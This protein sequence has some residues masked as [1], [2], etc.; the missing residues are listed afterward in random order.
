MQ[1]DLLSRLPDQGDRALT[2][3]AMADKGPRRNSGGSIVSTYQLSGTLFYVGTLWGEKPVRDSMHRLR[4]SRPHGRRWIFSAAGRDRED[5]KAIRSVRRSVADRTGSA[6]VPVRDSHGDEAGA[7]RRTSFARPAVQ[8]A[9]P[10]TPW[11]AD[12]FETRRTEMRMV[13]RAPGATSRGN[14]RGVDPRPYLHRV[15]ALPFAP[16]CHSEHH[17]PDIRAR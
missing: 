4:A 10:P 5:V 3:S 13:Y 6:S 11:R 9:T 8:G 17:E 12:P 7:T 2:P 1:S 15:R 14:R 16:R